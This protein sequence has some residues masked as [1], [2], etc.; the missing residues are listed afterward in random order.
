V[1]LV[2]GADG[3]ATTGDGPRFGRTVAASSGGL[4]DVLLS[5]AG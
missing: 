1:L 3:V 4:A 5:G 2:A